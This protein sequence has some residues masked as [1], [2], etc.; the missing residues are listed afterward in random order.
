MTDEQVQEII[1]KLIELYGDLLPNP[2][3]YPR[4]FDYYLR[5]YEHEK[6]S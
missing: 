3:H 4:T 2:E 6:N 1:K 5:L